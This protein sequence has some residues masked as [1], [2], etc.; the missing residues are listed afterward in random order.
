[1]KNSNTIAEGVMKIGDLVRF[2][3]IPRHPEIC[4]C[5]GCLGERGVVLDID[6]SHRQT[7]LSILSTSGVII[8]KVWIDYVE[9][10]CES[11]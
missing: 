11:R 8:K 4:E 1:M 7:S 2:K 3:S 5:R 6:D 10:F 9:A